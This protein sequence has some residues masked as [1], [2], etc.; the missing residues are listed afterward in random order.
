MLLAT[1]LEEGKENKKRKKKNKED[2]GLSYGSMLHYITV[3]IGKCTVFC[4]NCTLF[5]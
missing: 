3:S 4:D 2:E 5:L 1:E